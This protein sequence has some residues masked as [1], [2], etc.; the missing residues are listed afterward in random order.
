M[1]Y[2]FIVFL[3]DQ[4]ADGIIDRCCDEPGVIP[5][6]FEYKEK[7]ISELSQWDYGEYTEEPVDRQQLMAEIGTS[8]FVY[9]N[10]DYLLVT[11]PHSALCLYRKLENHDQ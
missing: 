2:Q 5:A 9:E 11:Y 7:L 4:E 3:Q 8:G 10:K 1:L 6:H